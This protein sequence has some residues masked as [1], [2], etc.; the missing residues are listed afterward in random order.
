MLQFW[1]ALPSLERL[2]QQGPLGSQ[3]FTQGSC[4]SHMS[5]AD[6]GV[7]VIG[8]L[9]EAVIEIVESLVMKLVPCSLV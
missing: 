8:L 4:E 5:E 3:T 1:A 2:I 7:I 6:I 9:L